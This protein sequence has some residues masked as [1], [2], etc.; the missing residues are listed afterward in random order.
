MAWAAERGATGWSHHQAGDLPQAA[1]QSG[2][3]VVRTGASDPF[4]SGPL[5]RLGI[6]PAAASVF[7]VVPHRPV[8][9][10]SRPARPPRR[11]RGSSARRPGSRGFASR[12]SRDRGRNGGRPDAVRSPR[13][14]RGGDHLRQRRGAAGRAARLILLTAVLALVVV[15]LAGLTARSLARPDAAAPPAAGDP[16]ETQATTRQAHTAGRAGRS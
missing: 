6:P 5:P 1:W 10:P 11:R 14:R 15:S 9:A 4:E 2:A 16:S 13:P 7:D 8:R 12:P 3:P